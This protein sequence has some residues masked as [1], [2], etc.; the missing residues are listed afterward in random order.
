MRPEK[1]KREYV[2]EFALYFERTGLSRSA[3]RIWAWLL[4][5]DP[6]HQTMDDLVEALNVSKSSVSTATRSLI[7]FGLIQRISLPDERRD[8]YRVTEGVWENAFQGRFGQVTQF[9]KLAEKGLDLL[10]DKPAEQ[11][12]P[13]QEMRDMYAFIEQAVPRLL[14]EWEEQRKGK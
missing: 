9:R 8:Y 7:Q 11:R 6:P 5:S 3:G 12:R 10:T 13:L 4:I 1:E 2:E 14:L